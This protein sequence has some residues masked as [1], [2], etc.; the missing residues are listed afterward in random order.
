MANRLADDQ[1]FKYAFA[2]LVTGVVANGTAAPVMK[3]FI[4]QI[5]GRKIEEPQLL[6]GRLEGGPAIFANGTDETLRQD[7]RQAGGDQKR[8]QTHVNET[9]HRARSIVR[10]QSAHDQVPGQR[11]LYGDLRSL[12]IANFTDHDDVRV[13]AQK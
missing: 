9:R 7:R 8:L 6:L 4:A 13:L 5:V 1:Q 10:V 3:N 11:R 12:E 2:A